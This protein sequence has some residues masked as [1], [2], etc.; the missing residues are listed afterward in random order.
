MGYAE[1]PHAAGQC[2]RWNA[3]AANVRHCYPGY[4]FLIILVVWENDDQAKLIFSRFRFFFW[5]PFR[6]TARQYESLVAGSLTDG[7]S[8]VYAP[9]SMTATARVSLLECTAAFSPNPRLRAGI[10]GVFQTRFQAT[11][12][13]L[14]VAGRLARIL[15][16]NRC[17]STGLVSK[18]E[19][20]TCTLLSRSLAKA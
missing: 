10:A 5:S 19:H 8:T 20:P 4:S 11:A 6:R 3:D 9:R 18:S 14:S 17:I 16:S 13:L 1:V 2:G 7:R 15:P 12:P